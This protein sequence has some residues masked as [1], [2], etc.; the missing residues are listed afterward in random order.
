[1]GTI[2]KQSHAFFLLFNV[3]GIHLSAKWLYGK[4]NKKKA[5]H[6]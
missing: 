5:P 1:M 3:H 4:K 2:L 6:C